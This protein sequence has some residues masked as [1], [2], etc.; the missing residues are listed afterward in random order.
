[1]LQHYASRSGRLDVCAFL[2]QSGA[3]TSPQTPGG[4]TPLHRA[5]YCGHLD[6]V[7]LLLRHGADPSLCDDDG[8]SPLHKVMPARLGVVCRADCVVSR[9]FQSE[10]KGVGGRQSIDQTP[11][12]PIAVS[13][14]SDM[15]NWPSTHI[16]CVRRR[17]PATDYKSYVPTLS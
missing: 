9:G 12:L 6:V 10:Q 15:G 3:C 4:A 17:R 11:D 14:R 1:M 5:A 16:H 7:G 13:M 2:L 8:A